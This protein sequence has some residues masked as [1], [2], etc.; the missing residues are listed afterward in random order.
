MSAR[1][2]GEMCMIETVGERVDEKKEKNET[3]RRLKIK[4]CG[5]EVG[6][7]SSPA[8]VVHPTVAVICFREQRSETALA[9]LL[10]NPLRQLVVFAIAR[11]G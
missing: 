10:N 11:R 2:S 4:R 3:E 1:R 5:W 9:G 6:R 8:L 7:A